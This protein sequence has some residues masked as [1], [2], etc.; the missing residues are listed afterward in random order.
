LQ[1][2][3]FGSSISKGLILGFSARTGYGR[4]LLGVPREEIRAKEGAKSRSGVTVIR[5]ASPVDIREG[6]KLKIATGLNEKTMCYSVFQISKDA[7]HSSPVNISGIMHEL[8]A[9]VDYKGNIRTCYS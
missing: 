2:S 6:N 7:F 1:P 8:R 9:F 5:A 4:L 3:Q